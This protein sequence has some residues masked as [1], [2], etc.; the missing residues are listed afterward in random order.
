[1][2][3]NPINL[4]FRFGLEIA[5]LTAFG[6]WG[7]NQADGWLKFILAL[8]I[9]L[10]ASVLWGIFA[11]PDDPSRS[12]KAPFPVPGLVRLALELVFFI[13]ACLAFIQKEMPVIGY[14]LGFLVILHYGLS[15]D[16]IQWLLNKK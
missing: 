14:F 3:S 13:L 16:R 12:G 5:A 1:M 2:G 4:I 6:I 9:P 10:L 8:G 7:W 11:V 15:Y